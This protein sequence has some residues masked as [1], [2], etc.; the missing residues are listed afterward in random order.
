MTALHDHPDFAD[1]LHNVASDLD[2][3]LAMVEKDY[4]VVATL[5]AIVDQG[6]EVW[7]KGGTS[8]SK[9]FQLIERFSEDLDVRL[10]AGTASGLSEP[11]R[12]WTND[13]PAAVKERDAWF[14]ALAGAM[15]VPGCSVHRDVAGSDPAFRS[16]CIEVRYPSVTGATLSAGM[17]PFVLVEVGRARVVPCVICPVSS[18]VGDWLAA[19]G[20][21]DLPAAPIVRLRC[22][23]P[24]V[25]ALEKVDA[26]ARRFPRDDRAP[27][28][29]IRHYED[30]ARIVAARDR[31]EPLEGGLGALR[32]AMGASKDIRPLPAAD[33][34]AFRP[35]GSERWN[36][37]RA[38]WRAMGPWYW[39]P[40]L[41]LEE[42][43]ASIRQALDE[44][45]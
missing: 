5:T 43:C 17:R 42:A 25:T 39:G 44:L 18:W 12:S 21:D 22:V 38:A 40:R 13:K 28:T 8:L 37:L 30:I 7:F 32:S 35:D 11:T 26:I 36:A 15:V 4:W 45:G 24:W 41:T 31:L 34:R 27:A 16:A 20:I 19:R 3:D 2:R 1:L 10:D 33:D 29:F 23:H 6:F 9:G 14:S